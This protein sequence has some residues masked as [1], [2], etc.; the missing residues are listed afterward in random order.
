MLSKVCFYASV[1]AAVVGWK[2]SVQT[3][4]PGRDIFEVVDQLRVESASNFD[5][6]ACREGLEGNG[7]I[8]D[9][10]SSTT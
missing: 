4:V 8:E 2:G 6:Y 1:I 3:F 9:S 5:P 10:S 7:D